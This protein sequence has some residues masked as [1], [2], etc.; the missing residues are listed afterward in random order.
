MFWTALKGTLSGSSAAGTQIRHT[1]SAV[2]LPDLYKIPPGCSCCSTVGCSDW[3][4][5][6]LVMQLHTGID[7]VAHMCSSNL[8]TG[9]TR[10]S[11]QAEVAHEVGQVYC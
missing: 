8:V 4:S 1:V 9:T 11:Y 2:A 7:A 6:G 5:M 3:P 10:P